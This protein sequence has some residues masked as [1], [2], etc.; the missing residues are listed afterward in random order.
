MRDECFAGLLDD[1]AHVLR[2]EVTLSA[3][4]SPRNAVY[5]Q[6]EGEVACAIQPVAGTLRETVIGRLEQATHVAYMEPRDVRAGDL[7]AECLAQGSLAEAAEQG[8]G[9]ITVAEGMRV[10][11]G[12]RLVVGEGE[13]AELAVAVV[14]SGAT[15]GLMTALERG[16]EAGDA[17]TK[18]TAY[19]VLA[20]RDEAGVGHH[21]R[22]SLRELTA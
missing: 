6:V 8:G 15:V 19:E 4:G 1:I 22:A 3:R 14:V 10:R 12:G 20:V 9:V 2:P 18:V 13:E 5:R 7:L 17:V 16:H 11:R 21:L